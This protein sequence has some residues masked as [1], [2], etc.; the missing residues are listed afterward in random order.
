MRYL[1]LLLVMACGV[2]NKA[3]DPKIVEI[4]APPVVSN[5]EKIAGYYELPNGGFIELTAL[6]DGRVRIELQQLLTTNN[7]DSLAWHPAFSS[8]PHALRADGSLVYAQNH[9]YSS[10]T[11]NVKK[12]GSNTDVT[13]SKR[14]EVV[15]YVNEKGNLVLT[16]RVKDGT[17]I[18]NTI[19]VSRTLESL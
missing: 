5:A 6:N 12:D 11:H 4:P 7:N 18:V 19:L 3:V 10:S 1:I 17:S 14:S 13:G 8:G 16:L 15:M 9:N 2:K